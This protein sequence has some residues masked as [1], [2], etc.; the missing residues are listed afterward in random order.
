MSRREPGAAYVGKG[1]ALTR[2]ARAQIA[3]RHEP[4]LT[5]PA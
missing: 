2:L 4:A 3:V 5:I 1:S